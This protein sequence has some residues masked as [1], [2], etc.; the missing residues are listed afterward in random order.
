MNVGELLRTQALRAPSRIAVR[1]AETG[2]G[3]TLQALD[4]SACRVAAA[5][6]ARGVSPG[7]H[8]AVAGRSSVELVAAIF[9]A[10]YAG[11]VVVPVSLGEAPGPLA[12][13][14]ARAG[15]TH[16]LVDDAGSALLARGEPSVRTS[17]EALAFSALCANTDA[18][19]ADGPLALPAGAQALLLA[20]SGTTGTPKGARIA[21]ASLL[22]HTALLVSD[23]LR[24]GPD[25]R[26][27]ATLPLAHSYGL[28]ITLLAPLLA[29]AEIVLAKRFDAARTL[30]AMSDFRVTFAP[31]VPTILAAWADTPR[32]DDEDLSA[33]RFV[34]SAGAPLTDA[35]A[36]RAEARLGCAVRQGYGMTEATFSTVDAPPAPRV[37]GSVGRAVLGVELRV[38]DADGRPLPSGEMGELIVRG[39]H[40]M[41]G[42]DDDADT[43]AVRLPGGFLRSGDLGRIDADGRVWVLDRAKDLILRGGANVAPSTVERALATAPGVREVAVFGV[44]DDYYGEEVV[45]AVRLDDGATPDADAL[46]AHA[47]TQLAR[48][49]VPR[50]FVFV[51][52]IPASATGKVDRRALRDATLRGALALARSAPRRPAQSE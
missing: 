5:L 3:T 4:D 28:R 31:V 40:T 37:L 35:L 9:G 47:E 1:D 21:H 20:T 17:L 14:L 45:A 2:A 16:A 30:H 7:T 33:L 44:P 36:L 25:D 26:V 29:G 11:A 52:A 13:R 34:L 23:A 15:C 48:H 43:A 8:V 32:W 41:L 12:M 46:S 19:R 51:E 49:E 18:P 10:A 38:I 50:A 22:V 6:V 39:H 27:L 24:L 42:Y